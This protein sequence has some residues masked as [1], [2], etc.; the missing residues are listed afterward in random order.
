MDELK[1]QSLVALL[2][3]YLDD[4]DCYN[5][6]PL[7]PLELFF[8][9]NDDLGSFGC[10]LPEHP[11]TDAFYSTLL[12]LRADPAATA[13]WVIAKQHDW[14]PAWP[15]SDEMVVR[16]RL[17]AEEIASRLDHLQPDTVDTITELNAPAHDVAGVSVGCGPGE[18][19]VVAWWD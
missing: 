19:Y 9:G 10:N 4:Q 18:H 2:E 1:R 14:K 13:V 16:T 8:D 6:T 11:G 12:E 15:H 3:P 17:D 5:P 7:L